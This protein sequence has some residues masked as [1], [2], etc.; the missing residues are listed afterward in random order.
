MK[1][2]EGFGVSVYRGNVQLKQFSCSS[3][4]FMWF[5]NLDGTES[6]NLVNSVMGVEK[7]MFSDATTAETLVQVVEWFGYG[8]FRV[9]AENGSSGTNPNNNDVLASLGKLRTCCIQR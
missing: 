4:D 7:C 9:T 2:N 6:H 8:S 1:A 3:P 5:K